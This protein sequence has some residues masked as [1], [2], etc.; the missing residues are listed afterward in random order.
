MKRQFAKKRQFAESYIMDNVSTEYLVF[1]CLF[2]INLSDVG[3][4]YRSNRFPALKMP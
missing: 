4:T 3:V 1:H 2:V